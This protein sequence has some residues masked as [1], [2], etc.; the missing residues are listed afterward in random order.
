MSKGS[1][2][3]CFTLNNYTEDERDALRN[4]KYAY[5]VFGYERG[6]EGTP[7][8]QGYVHLSTQKTLS[9]MKK[10]IP[11]AHLE[12]RQGTIDQAIKYCV[13]EGDYEEFGKKP[14]SQQEKRKRKQEKVAADQREG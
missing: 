14:M 2:S 9:A 11:R 13:K 10:M 4:G 1:R 3:W 8:L 5:M 6:V 12:I 7:H